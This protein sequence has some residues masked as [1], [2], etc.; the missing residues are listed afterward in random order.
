MLPLSLS[1]RLQNPADP[2]RP[3]LAGGRTS[4]DTAAPLRAGFG[5]LRGSGPTFLRALDGSIAVSDTAVRVAPP[6]PGAHVA[7]LVPDGGETLETDPRRPERD[8]D[9]TD[10]HRAGEPDEGAG[11]EGVMDGAVAFVPKENAPVQ[12]VRSDGYRGDV[13]GPSDATT[14]A[15][16]IPAGRDAAQGANAMSAISTGSVDTPLT[17]RILDASSVGPAGAG[18]YLSPVRDSAATLPIGEDTLRAAEGDAAVEPPPTAPSQVAIPSADHPTPGGNADGPVDTAGQSGSPDRSGL[19]DG[20]V[21]RGR[22]SSMTAR[23]DDRMATVPR[24]SPGAGPTPPSAGGDAAAPRSAGSPTDIALPVV[25]RDPFAR[26]AGTTGAAGMARQT[27]T[28]G[29]VAGR[30]VPGRVPPGDPPTSRVAVTARAPSQPTST[31]AVI[32]GPTFGPHPSAPQST[33]PIGPFSVP[34]A[35]STPMGMMAP[36]DRTVGPP[37]ALAPTAPPTAAVSVGDRMSVAAPEEVGTGGTGTRSPQGA[38]AASGPRTSGAPHAVMPATIAEGPGIATQEIDAR[39]GSAASVRTELQTAG[40]ASGSP[41]AVGTQATVNHSGTAPGAPTVSLAAAILAERAAGTAE[42]RRGPFDDDA[43]LAVAAGPIAMSG[44]TAPSIQ[45][46]AAASP[47]ATSETAQRIAQQLADVTARAGRRE[48]EIALAPA[49]LGRVRIRL[50]AMD[51]ALQVAILAERPET[52]DLMRRHIAE[53]GAEFRA[54][55]YERVDFTFS[56]PGGDAGGGT[57][58]GA[59]PEGRGARQ[60]APVA[61]TIPAPDSAGSRVRSATG[62]LDLRL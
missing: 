33:A 3:E 23:D 47:A 4:G 31:R 36:P 26:A 28:A 15:M 52:L 7:S 14:P 45:I 17:G 29:S 16:S 10:G 38:V 56:Q 35:A 60:S 44:P 27:D 46:G 62:T 51:G 24:L 39:T 32:Q 22:P 59:P 54:Q 34:D 50:M 55:G 9:E 21:H 61:D 18:R 57:A 11:E 48:A 8:A 5:G 25:N 12:A 40:A 2:R 6:K 19:T 49:E 58:D 1:E 41:V 37:A 13:A 42:S 53:L 20:I 30:F 43:R